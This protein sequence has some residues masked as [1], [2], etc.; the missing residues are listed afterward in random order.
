MNVCAVS[1][2]NSVLPG[3]G[4]GSLTIGVIAKNRGSSAIGAIVK[5]RG[6][7]AIGAAVNG[8]GSS[9]VG[10]AANGQPSK[11]QRGNALHPLK[12]PAVVAGIVEAAGIGDFR[13]GLP[14]IGK[15]RQAFFDPAGEYVAEGGNGQMTA[16]Q[17]AAG[18]FTDMK[19]GGQLLQ[20]YR[21]L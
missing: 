10:A 9:T 3:N 7:S 2:G 15:Q 14:G 21:L 18:A 19:G 17:A 5:G 13:N 12:G 4:R 20:G 1:T 11:L 6:S 8:R 16:E